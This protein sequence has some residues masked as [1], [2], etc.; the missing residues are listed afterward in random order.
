[1]FA[2]DHTAAAE[3]TLPA[4][5]AT[6]LLPTAGA[7]GAALTLWALR[8]A[9]PR[10]RAA[11][12]ILLMFLVLLYSVFLASIVLSGAVLALGLVSSPGPVAVEQVRQGVG[13]FVAEL[14]SERTRTDHAP[15]AVAVAL[16]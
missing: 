12:R 16:R 5:A 10:P 9:G 11:S 14:A 13:Q 3:F 6:R 4:A 7:G 1:M 15:Q 8:R 2:P